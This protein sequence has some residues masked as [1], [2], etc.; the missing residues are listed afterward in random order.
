MESFFF[1]WSAKTAKQCWGGRVCTAG[2]G[3]GEAC[4]K[5]RAVLEPNLLALFFKKGGFFQLAADF[6][7]VRR[8]ASRF[9][10][11]GIQLRH[12]LSTNNFY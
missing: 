3:L 12:D 7:L 11:L 8:I 9:H 1:T 4:G 5:S 10:K 2:R 6:R